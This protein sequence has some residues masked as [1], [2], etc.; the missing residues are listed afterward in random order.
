MKTIR[1][2]ID[3]ELLKKLDAIRGRSLQ[4]IQ[5]E[6]KEMTVP[7]IEQ[8]YYEVKSQ[9]E[10]EVLSRLI[11]IND[12]KLSLVFCNTKRRVDELVDKPEYNHSNNQISNLVNEF[13]KLRAEMAYK[14]ALIKSMKDEKIKDMQNQLNLLQLEYQKLLNQLLKPKP[15]KW[16]QFWN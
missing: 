13:E 2:K 14:D 10:P 3:E 9:A 12:I 1:F 15:H 5:L 16:W 7:E 6:H 11:D 8:F 4:M